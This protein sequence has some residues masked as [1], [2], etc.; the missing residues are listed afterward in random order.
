L[1]DGALVLQVTPKGGFPT[2][3]SP[4]S[5]TPP[6]TRL[7]L[8]GDDRVIALDEPFKDAR[9]EFLRGPDGRIA[10]LRIG[11]RVHAR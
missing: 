6:P 10:W 4:A 9:G 2:K 1:R 8:C 11:G 3:D 5:P 7:A